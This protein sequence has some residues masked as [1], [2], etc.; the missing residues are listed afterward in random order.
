MCGISSS[1]VVVKCV[2]GPLGDISDNGSRPKTVYR[3]ESRL[4]AIYPRPQAW[5][6]HIAVTRDRALLSSTSPG[7]VG[8]HKCSQ[9]GLI[10]TTSGK[11]TRDRAIL[12]IRNIRCN[13]PHMRLSQRA[14]ALAFPMP[15]N[16]IYALACTNERRDVAQRINMC[17][18]CMRGMHHRIDSI[19][20]KVVPIDYQYIM[21][22][23]MAE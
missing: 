6:L 2:R 1:S 23:L 22:E 13:R 9:H 16:D 17:G 18:S 11:H 5:S 15:P 20:D 19:V 14:I 4:S 7:T 3:R 12:P 10:I 8:S 21:L